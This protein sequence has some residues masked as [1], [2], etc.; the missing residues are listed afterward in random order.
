MARSACLLRD[1]DLSYHDL[2][3]AEAVS[4]LSTI[5]STKGQVILPKSIRD[6]LHW[7][8]GTRLVVE[9]TANGVLLRQAEQLFPP[10]TLEEVMGM[11]KYD[12]PART[13]EEMDQAVLA[14]AARQHAR[15]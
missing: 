14:E 11:L 2:T 8:S 13:I 4:D 3:K 15:R 10:T 7:D 6:A 9:Q 5:V 12:G 1:R